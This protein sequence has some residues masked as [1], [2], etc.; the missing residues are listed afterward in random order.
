[1]SRALTS[2]LRTAALPSSFFCV[3]SVAPSSSPCAVST[4]CVLIG[5]LQ[6][7]EFRHGIE[8]GAIT[9]HAGDLARSLWAF[10]NP[11]RRLAY[12][13]KMVSRQQLNTKWRALLLPR[14]PRRA[15]RATAAA[16][17]AA[18]AVAAAVVPIALSAAALPVAVV[19]G[20]PAVLA[21]GGAPRTLQVRA[22]NALRG[23]VPLPLHTEAASCAPVAF[24][25]VAFALA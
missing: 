21:T 12:F 22:S 18:A 6:Y 20:V 2:A 7:E 1:M 25:P 14:Q 16:A 4:G 15:K 10:I 23:G 5:R 24:A 17:A 13:E 19:A 11:Q 8:S 9:V 3:V